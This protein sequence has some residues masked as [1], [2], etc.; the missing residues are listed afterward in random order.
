[1]AGIK[2]RDPGSRKQEKDLE[3]EEPEEDKE[4]KDAE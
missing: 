3:V 2:A 1:L 4:E